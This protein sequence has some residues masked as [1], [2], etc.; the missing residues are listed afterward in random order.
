VTRGRLG[1]GS[2]LDGRRAQGGDVID[3]GVTSTSTS[4]SDE[5]PRRGAAAR[6]ERVRLRGTRSAT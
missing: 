2:G 3:A 1:R 4:R 6:R 5:R